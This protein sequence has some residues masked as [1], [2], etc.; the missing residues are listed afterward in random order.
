MSLSPSCRALMPTSTRYLS[1]GQGGGLSTS[2]VSIDVMVI[3]GSLMYAQM[4]R[5]VSTRSPL[6]LSCSRR[7]L[8]TILH[9]AF[10]AALFCAVS[11]MSR[12]IACSSCEVISSRPG[13][14]GRCVACR[15]LRL[16]HDERRACVQVVLV[17]RWFVGCSQVPTCR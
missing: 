6:A 1:C 16:L 11:L 5:G 9:C 8:T 13:L 15:P 17:V 12:S 14:L 10:T 3:R 4:K 2:A 7:C